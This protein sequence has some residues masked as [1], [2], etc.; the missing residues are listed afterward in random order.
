M[1]RKGPPKRKKVIPDPIYNSQ[2]VSKFINV[3]LRRGK[4]S[5]AQRIVYKAFAIIEKK[6]KEQP[7]T[8]FKRAIDNVRPHIAVKSRRVGGATYQVP[9]EVTE[10]RGI[11]L[12][13]RWIISFAKAQKGKPMEERLASEILNAMNN[14]GPAVKKK[15]DTHKM[16]EANKAFAHYRW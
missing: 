5:L 11:A 2:L 10:G 16:A 6:T 8:V 4:K 12:A 7:L 9:T 14:T 1:P 13:M 3:I 15:E